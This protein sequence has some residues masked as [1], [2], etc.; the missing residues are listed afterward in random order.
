[1]K[2]AEN[3]NKRKFK[4]KRKTTF[5]VA[6]LLVGAILGYCL[7]ARRAPGTESG[8]SEMAQT[9]QTNADRDEI[10]PE[11]TF[12][13]F[14]VNIANTN[15]HRF[16]KCTLTVEFDDKAGVTEAAGKVPL[17]RDAIIDVLSSKTLEELE[18]GEPR[19]AL[20]AELVEAVAR[21]IAKADVKRVFF[22][23][24]VVQ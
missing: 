2:K 4:S 11:Y 16:L 18:P 17:L 15:G 6:A 21:L 14:I 22:S 12:D 10:G 3:G 23:E 13:T 5:A 19:D 9:E 1:M 8:A 24:F 7:V 20:R